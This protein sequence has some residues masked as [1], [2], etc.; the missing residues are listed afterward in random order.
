MFVGKTASPAISRPLVSDYAPSRPIP[1]SPPPW[2]I[3]QPHA[4]EVELRALVGRL[5]RHQAPSPLVQTAWPPLMR[6]EHGLCAVRCW[7][8]LVS[9]APLAG[10]VVARGVALA[11]PRSSPAFPRAARYTPPQFAFVRPW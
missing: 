11:F 3:P 2:A 8:L 7:P 9:A 4:G 1:R 5:P 6:W 10:R